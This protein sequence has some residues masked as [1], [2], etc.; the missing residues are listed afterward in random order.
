MKAHQIAEKLRIHYEDFLEVK[1]NSHEYSSIKLDLI[2]KCIEKKCPE[3][4]SVLFRLLNMYNNSSILPEDE[5]PLN[6]LIK[7]FENQGNEIDEMIENSKKQSSRM[8]FLSATK[9]FNVGEMIDILLDRIM[10]EAGEATFQ[11]NL[12]RMHE[13]FSS[14]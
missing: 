12:K 9:N 3:N 5:I 8:M 11:L 1:N 14:Y 7:V 4:A 2:N 6:D 10:N 13:S